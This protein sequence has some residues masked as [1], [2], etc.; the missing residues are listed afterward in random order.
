MGNAGRS[1]RHANLAELVQN[2]C[3]WRGDGVIAQWHA[4]YRMIAV[5]DSVQ[6]WRVD[7]HEFLQ[8]DA[9]DAGHF[10]GIAGEFA[11]CSGPDNHGGDD[12]AGTGG[13]IVESP[14]YGAGLQ[15]QANFFVE[16]SQ[17]GLLRRLTGIDAATGQGPLASVA[18][19]AKRAS[20][21]NQRSLRAPP[22]G[23]G[24]PW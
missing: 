18:P 22:V 13:E 21:Q 10:G 11:R 8:R 20:R 6:Q 23:W 3:S 5:L 2:R 14:Q 7:A 1:P 12:E 4:K 15:S 19:Q 17:R 9:V 24:D 16:F